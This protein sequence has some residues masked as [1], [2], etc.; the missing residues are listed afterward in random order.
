MFYSILTVSLFLFEDAFNWHCKISSYHEVSAWTRFWKHI[1]VCSESRYTNLLHFP[2]SICLSQAISPDIH[3]FIETL[4]RY[5]KFGYILI[6]LCCSHWL[7]PFMCQAIL[8]WMCLAKLRSC[9]FCHDWIGVGAANK[10]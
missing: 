4:S 1:I 5:F 6:I 9:S 3:N 10:T 8:S 2:I 7:W